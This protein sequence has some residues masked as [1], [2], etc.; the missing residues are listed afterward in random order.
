M[1]AE[2]EVTDKDT[3]ENFAPKF[4]GCVNFD[5]L[6]TDGF[7]KL[8]PAKRVMDSRKLLLTKSISCLN[9]SKFSLLQDVE[10]DDETAPKFLPKGVHWGPNAFSEVKDVSED[11]DEKQLCADQV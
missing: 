5:K 10:Q 4:A 3:L 1:N 7:S 11:N 9:N 8:V 6:G 2:S